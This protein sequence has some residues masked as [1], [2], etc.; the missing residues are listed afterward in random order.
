MLYWAWLWTMSTGLGLSDDLVPVA[1][2]KNLYVECNLCFQ[3]DILLTFAWEAMHIF[4]LDTYTHIY[5]MV[6]WKIFILWDWWRLR[7]GAICYVGSREVCEMHSPL[8]G[9]SRRFFAVPHTVLR[10]LCT[11][12][13]QKGVYVW[14]WGNGNLPTFPSYLGS[15]WHY[16]YPS[17]SNSWL[18]IIKI[19]ATLQ[20][21]VY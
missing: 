11:C 19:N 14:D 5:S 15:V 13:S 3:I 10:P 1:Q 12:K 16:F 8:W 20:Y 7:R 17:K 4:C 18:Y 6:S 2:Y 21:C 9:H